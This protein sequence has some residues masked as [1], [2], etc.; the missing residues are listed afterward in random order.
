M[1]IATLLMYLAK[2]SLQCTMTQDTI[3]VHRLAKTATASTKLTVY[4]KPDSSATL[5]YGLIIQ[6][7]DLACYYQN[8]CLFSV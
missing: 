2:K 6:V 3:L 4:T 5:R 7:A 1:A 8:I